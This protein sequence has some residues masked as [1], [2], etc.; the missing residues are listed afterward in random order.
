M[1]K[2]FVIWG[3][4][5]KDGE[6][7]LLMEKCLGKPITDEK[8]AKDIKQL[9]KRKYKCHDVRIQTIAF[10]EDISQMFAKAVKV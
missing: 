1:S 9:L 8:V 2:E 5:S 10:D 3:K 6:E 4:T 7:K